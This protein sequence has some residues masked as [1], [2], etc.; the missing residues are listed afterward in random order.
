M[1][2]YG[3]SVQLT[4]TLASLAN[5]ATSVAGRQSTVVDNTSDLFLDALVGG[6]ITTG[7]S[8]TSGGII[9]VWAFAAENDTPTYPDGLGATD[10]AIAFTSRDIAV[11]SQALV[12]SLVV[13]TTSNQTYW[14]KA[15]SIAALFGGV[16]P[17]KWGVVVIN[18]SGVA[19]NATAGNH[20][21]FYTPLKFA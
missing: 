2:Q 3:A 18:S 6:Q 16:L 13:D 5:S 14:F 10:A 4:I 7:T 21:L 20:A 17:R 11:A 15:T 1:L 12:T 8:P 9:E 19:L